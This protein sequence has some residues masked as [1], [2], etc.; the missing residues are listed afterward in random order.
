MSSNKSIREKMINISKRDENGKLHYYKNLQGMKFGRLMPI[1]YLY[2][3]AR[4]KAVWLCKCDCGKKIEVESDRLATGN[5]KSC[6]CLHSDESKKRAKLM[7]E[8][9]TKYRR[10][11]E[12]ELAHIF[13]AMKSRCYNPECKAYKNYGGRGITIFQDWLDDFNNFYEWSIKNKYEKSLS[14][15][16]INVNG[17][18]EPTNCRW[19]T[20]LQQQNNRRNNH[21]ITLNEQTH[22]CAEWSRITGIPAGT[23]TDRIRRG[24]DAE[25]ILNAK[26]KHKV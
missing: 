24:W 3:N 22:T 9:K 17:N 5:T 13:H 12:K 11:Y 1:K 14:I 16:R 8:A 20:N 23:I 6:G 15:D 21:F 19:V 7:I 25:R 2:T 10:I 18:Y 4:K 26:Y